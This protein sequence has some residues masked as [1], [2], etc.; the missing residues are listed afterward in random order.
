MKLFRTL[1]QSQGYEVLEAPEGLVGLDLARQH[2]P[3]L[4]L[5]DIE[6]PDISG[7]EIIRRLKADERMRQIPVVAVTASMADQ[8]SRIRASGCDDFMTKPFAMSDFRRML[9][10]FLGDPATA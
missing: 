5:M 4:I 9:K 8:E 2:H 1:L 7:V 6:L 10:S 3:D